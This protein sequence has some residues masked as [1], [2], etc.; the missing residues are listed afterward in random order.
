M[1]SPNYRRTIIFSHNIYNTEGIRVI[2]I[3]KKV[4]RM[5]LSWLQLSHPVKTWT[6]YFPYCDYYAAGILIS[7]FNI[8]VNH[9]K[10]KL[11]ACLLGWCY[12]CYTFLVLHQR[13][14]GINEEKYWEKII[15]DL[16]IEENRGT[17]YMS[18][19][20]PQEIKK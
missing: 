9:I 8:S 15:K 7:S 20:E 18:N 16:Y 14:C 2:M 13:K 6:S 11:I 19:I 1:V 4:T 3:T 10:L 17:D 12:V 5:L